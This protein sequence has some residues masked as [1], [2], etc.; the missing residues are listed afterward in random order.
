MIHRPPRAHHRLTSALVLCAGLGTVML[1]AA[2]APVDATSA[3]AIPTPSYSLGLTFGNQLHH[4]GLTSEVDMQALMRGIQD[5]L[6]GKQ[7]TQADKQDASQFLMG[8]RQMVGERNKIAARDFLA[9]NATQPGIKSTASGLQY[10]I[11]K[12][13]EVNGKSPDA[14]SQ[15]TVQYRGTLLDGTE[16]DSSIAHG[17]AAIFRMNSIM[18]GW[19]EALTLMKPGAKWR[20]FVPPELGYDLRTPPSIPP[21]SLLTYE[22]ELQHV[23]AAG[24]FSRNAGQR[25]ADGLKPSSTPKP[26]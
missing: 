13:G 24:D 23:A 16:F 15:V 10:Q 5:G 3:K 14:A 7:P 18:R 6:G 12:P 17:Q 22:I 26:Q 8:A 9:K 2:Q 25:S 1:A 11:L 19:Q 4:G 21:G 20:I